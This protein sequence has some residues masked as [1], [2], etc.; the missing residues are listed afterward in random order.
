MSEKILYKKRK[1][2]DA[3]LYT[4]Y[5]FPFLGIYVAYYNDIFYCFISI[6]NFCISGYY[7]LFYEK[8]FKTIDKYVSKISI[9]IFIFDA[10]RLYPQNS[11]FFFFNVFTN[12]I[13]M[14][15]CFYLSNKESSIAKKR[16]L[17]ENDILYNYLHIG[18]H[19]FATFFALGNHYLQYH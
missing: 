14:T 10:I 5:L 13:P 16:L 18:I 7:H 19:Y 2:N 12:L 1:Y 15:Y 9:M 4:N 8:K 3:I 6:V 17:I 11:F